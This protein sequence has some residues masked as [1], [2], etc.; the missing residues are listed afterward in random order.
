M[1]VSFYDVLVIMETK[2][3]TR[4]G[5]EMCILAYQLLRCHGNKIQK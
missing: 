2:K 3:N 5:L 1:S 4:K